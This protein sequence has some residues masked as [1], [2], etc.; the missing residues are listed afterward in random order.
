M[1][2]LQ[3]SIMYSLSKHINIVAKNVIIVN[4]TTVG[5]VPIVFNTP[6]KKLPITSFAL[7]KNPPQRI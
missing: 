1:C 7:S 4:V 5:I 6:V 3:V 2:F